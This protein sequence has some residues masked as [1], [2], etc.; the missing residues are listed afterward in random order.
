[1]TLNNFLKLHQNGTCDCISITE[2]PEWNY[3]GYAKEKRICEEVSQE[4][5]TK[6]D[7]YKDLW[8]SIKNRQVKHF[9]IIGGGMYPVEL[10]IYIEEE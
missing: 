5:L 8:K 1:M 9:C 6:S 3:G 10:T 4:S 7:V 2:E